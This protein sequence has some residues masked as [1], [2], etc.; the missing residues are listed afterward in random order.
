VIIPNFGGFVLNS[1]DFKLDDEQVI[2]PKSKWVAFNER[3][4]SDDGLLATLWAKE[5]NISQK[6]AFAAVHQ[7]GQTLAEQIKAD[8][9]FQFGNIGVFQVSKSGRLQFEPNQAIN[10][11]L[12]QYG[13]T[14]VSLGTLKRNLCYKKIQW[15]SRQSI[16][17]PSNLSPNELVKIN[18]TR[19]CC[20]PFSLEELQPT[21]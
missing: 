17:Q 12:N 1:Q 18:F 8:K 21:I 15:R 10:F 13:L 4:Q 2:H 19:M 3:L 14:P 5:K 6:Q 7:F 20:W 16:C 11:D 9:Q